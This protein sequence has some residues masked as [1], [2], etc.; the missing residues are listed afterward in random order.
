MTMKV[1]VTGELVFSGS[2][3]VKA[4]RSAGHQVIFTSRRDENIDNGM[5]NLGEISAQTN[6]T[7]LLRGC[8]TVIHTAGRAHIPMIKPKIR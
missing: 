8:D 5:Y 2:A 4:L 6:W 7:T 3:L 1:L